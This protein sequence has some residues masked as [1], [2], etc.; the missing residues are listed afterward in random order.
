MGV[1]E[2]IEE[3]LIEATT[4]ADKRTLEMMRTQMT[5]ESE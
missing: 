5:R 2:V 1:V 4:T 3:M